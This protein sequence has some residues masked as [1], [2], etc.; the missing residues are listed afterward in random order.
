MLFAQISDMHYLREG[1]LAFGKVDTHACLL[2]C[3]EQIRALDPAP[4]ALLIT[5]D[6]TNDGDPE[7]YRALADLLSVLELP[8]YPIPG[9]HDDRD[10]I[11]NAFPMV[12][13]LSPEGPLCYAIEHFPVRLLAL[14]SSVDGKPYGRLGAAQ[15]DWLA[16]RLGED[17]E[18]PV[19]VM[20]HHPPF[21]TGI[22]HMDFSMLKD[23]EALAAVI[24]AHPQV[25][26]V[27]CGH[28]HRAVQVRFAGTIAQIAPGSAH[29][30]KL[31]LGAGRGPWNSEP[32]GLL[33]H[34][35]Q[36]ETG[37]IT[38]QLSIGDFKPEG[39]FDDPHTGMPTGGSPA[40]P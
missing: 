16:A 23:A 26:R 21:K 40:R 9:N 18:K 13:V 38:H 17:A 6:L 34:C 3:V 31:V 30:I 15:L 35:W 12:G 11:R 14:D 25:E 37:L 8:I 27:L 20:L 7:A 33:L 5:G 1:V 19:I 4:D 22:G 10:L 39:R 24:Q 2:R 32:P 28:V 36:E 29:Q